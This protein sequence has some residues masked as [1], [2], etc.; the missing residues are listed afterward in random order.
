MGSTCS[1]S[2]RRSSSSTATA[3][4]DPRRTFTDTEEGWKAER[5]KGPHECSFQPSDLPAFQRLPVHSPT[6]R[7]K[8]ARCSPPPEDQVQSPRPSEFGGAVMGPGV[9]I[10]VIIFG[11][12]ILSSIKI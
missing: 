5:P 6:A 2:P 4:K 10:L 12:Y 1:S 11:I 3:A 9:L 8:A 7:R